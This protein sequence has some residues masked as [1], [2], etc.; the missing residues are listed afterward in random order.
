M[1]TLNLD[2]DGVISESRTK[3]KPKMIRL[4]KR[5]ADKYTL[6]VISGGTLNLMKYQFLDKIRNEVFEVFLLPTS[7]LKCYTS[8]SDV[9]TIYSEEM[10]KEIKE[11][12]IRVISK[13]IKVYKL[14]PITF[15]VI[16][17]RGAQITYSILGRIAPLK[18]K[19]KYDTDGKKRKYYIESF[20]KR[21]LEG[22]NIVVGGT[23]SID[24]TMKGKDKGY[25]VKTFLKHFNLKSKDCVFFGD[26]LSNGGNDYPI[27]KIIKKC[28]A[29]KN[30]EDAY[31]KLR[32][33]L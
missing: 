7:G 17:D 21:R 13:M 18:E 15:D 23:T 19:K 5:L 8:N 22:I 12:I 16:E 11:K 27:R 33:L 31:T 28:V 14:Q 25:G 24:F 1:N 3:T 29:V 6:A 20:L 30:P 2:M 10:P 4:L 26:K 9:E 32:G